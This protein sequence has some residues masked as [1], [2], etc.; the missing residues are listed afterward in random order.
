[1]VIVDEVYNSGHCWRN[2]QQWSLLA[3]FTI[4]VIVGGAYSTGHCWRSSWY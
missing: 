2:L 3:E 1:M 4:V